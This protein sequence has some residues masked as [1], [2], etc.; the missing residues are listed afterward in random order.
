M[1]IALI[2]AVYTFIVVRAKFTPIVSSA[3]WAAQKLIL[4]KKSLKRKPKQQQQEVASVDVFAE[5]PDK[6]P[7][8]TAQKAVD[9]SGE[10]IGKLIAELGKIF[11]GVDKRIK[12]FFIALLNVWFFTGAYYHIVWAFTYWK[13]SLIVIAIFIEWLTWIKV[14]IKPKEEIVKQ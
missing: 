14:N 6:K 7:L 12:Y 4:L 1:I 3:L 9:K 2:I 10:E 11:A 13:I 5:L 8:T